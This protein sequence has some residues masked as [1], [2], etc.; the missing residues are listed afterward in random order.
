MSFQLAFHWKSLIYFGLYWPILGH[1]GLF[2]ENSARDKVLANF[3]G[4]KIYLVKIFQKCRY[5]GENGGD[6]KSVENGTLL[7]FPPFQLMKNLC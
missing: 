3:M 7:N 1:C 2:L 5:V 4:Y 6:P